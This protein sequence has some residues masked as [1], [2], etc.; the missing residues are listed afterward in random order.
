[1]PG[2]A[3]HPAGLSLND[4]CSA[5]RLQLHQAR[6][7]IDLTICLYR[8]GFLIRLRSLPSLADHTVHSLSEHDSELPFDGGCKARRASVRLGGKHGKRNGYLCRV[9]FLSL[10]LLVEHQRSAQRRRGGS[11]RRIKKKLN[12]NRRA[13]QREEAEGKKRPANRRREESDEVCEN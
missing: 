10:L 3:A 7:L 8:M 6:E 1:V 9:A 4:F 2:D 5:L 11:E 12:M 13:H